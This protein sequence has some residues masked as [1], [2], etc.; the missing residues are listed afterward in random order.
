TAARFGR[1]TR[2][3]IQR[4]AAAVARASTVRALNGAGDGR[5]P[6]RA[7]RPA[8]A[9]RIGARAHPAR[10]AAAVVAALLVRAVGRAESGRRRCAG[11]R[12]GRWGEPEAVDGRADA[13]VDDAFVRI[14]VAAREAVALRLGPRPLHEETRLRVLD[15][16]QVDGGV[17][18]DGPRIALRL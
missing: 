7:R 17:L 10:A 12:G 13:R 3:A 16:D 4:P 11:P 14:H 6:A 1:R 2:P 15:A 5:A 8:A 9:A 18:L